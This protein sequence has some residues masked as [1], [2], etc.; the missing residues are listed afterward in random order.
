MKARL[1][2]EV[3]A[4]NGWE[5][6]QKK[7][8]VKRVHTQAKIKVRTMTGEHKRQLEKV[9]LDKDQEVHLSKEERHQVEVT[10]LVQQME[11]LEVRCK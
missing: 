10:K 5:L 1:I 7:E 9:V 2:Q 3:N 4:R 11:S 8:K 6:Q